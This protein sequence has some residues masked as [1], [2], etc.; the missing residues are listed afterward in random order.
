MFSFIWENLKEHSK[1]KESGCRVNQKSKQE[2]LS[3][4]SYVCSESFF[5]NDLRAIVIS[6]LEQDQI[7]KQ[8]RR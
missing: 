7:E 3:K 1:K 2:E 6:Q 8:E 5:E 4:H